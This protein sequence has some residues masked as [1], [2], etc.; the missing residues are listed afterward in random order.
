MSKEFDSFCVNHEIV[1]RHTVH[2]KSQ[3]NDIAEHFNRV[4]SESII[5][6]LSESQLPL[7]FWGE[8]LAAFVHVHNRYSTSALP[9][10]TL[11]EM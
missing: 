9:D 10:T 3:Q 2:N 6:M 1:R 4:L 5:T 11:F 8:A 7:Q